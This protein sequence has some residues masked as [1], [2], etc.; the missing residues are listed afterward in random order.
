MFAIA[1]WDS[2]LRQLVLARDRLGKKPLFYQRLEDQVL[3][4][5]ELKALA[6]AATFQAELNPAAIDQFLTYQYVP[7]PHCIYRSSRKVAPAHCEV[8]R[9]DGSQHSRCYWKFD[10]S[11][12]RELSEAQASSQ[13]KDLLDDSIQLRLRSDVPL[14]AFLSGGVD[15]SLIVALS[16]SKLKQPLHTFSIGFH[17]SD[18]DESHYARQVAGWVGTEHHEYHVQPD[19]IEVLD[20][21]A[22]HY[23]EPF[24]DSSALPT[25]HLCQ[26]TRQHVTVALSGD[27]GDELFAGYDRYRALWLSS[28]MD[29]LLPIK[30]I[31][32]SRLIQRIPV[33]ANR[34]SFV[35][36]LQRFGE[37]LN[38]PMARRY[39]NWLQ[40]FSEAMRS[41]LYR[42][43]FV[44]Q[45]PNE[46]PFLFFEQAWNQ[47]GKRDL[48]SRA[49]LSDLITYLPCDLMNKVDVAS[50]AHS[51]ECRQPFL[52]YRLVEWAAG[53]PLSFKHRHGGGKRILRT[54]FDRL[55]PQ[56]IWTRKKMGFGVPLNH[57][58]KDQLLPLTRQRLLSDD[59]RC[60]LY[61]RREVIQRLVDQH[62]SGSTSHSY[63]LWNLLMFESWL[64][65]WCR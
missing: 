49:S 43:E 63:R 32:G 42:D 36:R 62:V 13:L 6:A 31:L 19:A 26:K 40:I 9:G 5:S 52:D 60:H 17:E 15:S 18:F 33:S 57:W 24:G 11:I 29:N 4:G 35:R 22:Y 30:P 20:K 48:I 10:P 8:F 65:R 58:F 27:G 46:D 47:V 7:H 61:F 2:R 37:A 39:M 50:M 3:F 25:W 45:L 38:Q 14:G 1:L 28:W 41:D 55:L 12:Q 54:V 53:L 34:R 56:Q 16:Q 21:L 23:D 59:T 51:L 64:R 44:Q